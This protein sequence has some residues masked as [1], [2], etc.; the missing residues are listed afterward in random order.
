M[1]ELVGVDT[2][3]HSTHNKHL[4]K[5]IL[6]VITIMCLNHFN[7]EW[8]ECERERAR[9]S[10]N[11]PQSFGFVDIEKSS[12][13]ICLQLTFSFV[14]SFAARCWLV[15]VPTTCS[16]FA[17]N[18]LFYFGLTARLGS[19]RIWF[20]FS[21]FVCWLICLRILHKSFLCLSIRFFFSVQLS[22]NTYNFE[23]ICKCPEWARV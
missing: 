22:A 7:E 20:V 12:L 5:S 1:S 11:G 9:A 6:F 14:H 23:W 18:F 19:V 13:G 3:A 16:L 21:L 10:A 17:Q 15:W 4:T 2:T 8:R